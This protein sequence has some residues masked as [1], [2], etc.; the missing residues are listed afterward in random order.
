MNNMDLPFDPFSME[1]T[2]WLFDEE[3]IKNVLDRGGYYGAAPVH[4]VTKGNSYEPRIYEARYEIGQYY[5]ESYQHEEIIRQM[6]AH[7]NKSRACSGIDIDKIYGFID[8]LV[9]FP[10]DEAEIMVMFYKENTPPENFP[11]ILSGAKAPTPPMPNTFFKGFLEEDVLHNYRAVPRCGVAHL[12][13]NIKNEPKPKLHWWVRKALFFTANDNPQKPTPGEFV[14]LA[15]RLFVD[16]YWRHQLTNPFLFSANWLD[17]L[18]FTTGTVM[19]VIEPNENRPFPVYQVKWRKNQGG[20]SAGE[21]DIFWCRPSGFETY[22][23]GD[24]VTILKDANTDRVSQTWK[25]DQNFDE[26]LWRIVP[27]TFYEYAKSK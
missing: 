10:Y 21:E 4:V 26:E 18:Y 17:T 14:G 27:I 22:Q 8:F 5:S 2:Y 1:V 7:I 19:G 25:D 13:P 12:A 16:R 6:K 23:A 9:G 20:Q 15:I 24:V 3:E 11:V